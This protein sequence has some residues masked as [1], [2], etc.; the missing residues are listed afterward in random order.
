MPA[1][2]QITPFDLL[3]ELS[4]GLRA[5]AGSIGIDNYQPMEMQVKFHEADT[6]GRV[7]SGGN[8][9]GKTVAGVAEDVLWLTGKH[10]QWSEVFPP[11]VRG[12]IVA[13]D[14]DRG[15]DKIIIPELQKWIPV[16]YLINGK[17]DDSYSHKTKT[18]TLTNGS[19]VELMSYDQDWDK[20]AG[21]SRHFCHFDEEPP[22]NIFNECLARL[23]DTN[24]RWW[25][26][27]TPLEEFSWTAE[28]IYEPARD[29]AL[30]GLITLIE[31]NT[32]QNIHIDS[33][34][35]DEI[36]GFMDKDE[37][38]ARKTGAGYGQAS[39]IF[40]ELAH[41]DKHLLEDVFDDE[42]KWEGMRR[43]WHHFTMMDHGLR[44]PTAILFAAIGPEGDVIVYD[45][46]YASDRLVGDNAEA[47]NARLDE[48]NI[49][50]IYMVGDPSTKNTDPITGTSIRIE[51][52]EHG[53][54]YQLGNN[55]V[56]A[57]IQR[58][59]SVLKHNHLFITKR[60]VNVL[61]E[62]RSY[63]WAKPVSS[64]TAARSNLMEHP[65]KRNDHA[66]DALRYGV[67]TLPEF[68]E[69]INERRVGEIA[70]IVGAV[71][72]APEE[73]VSDPYPVG[74]GYFDEHLGWIEE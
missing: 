1:K 47:Y 51:Y 53:V 71:P 6:R 25:L 11:P 32:D 12:R 42:E 28:A 56:R 57:G 44:N 67:M 3:T 10:P 52:G 20:F 66:M 13:V 26:T 19:F 59:K 40:P 70:A 18:L 54:W 9:S 29:G 8:R 74:A 17:W 73:R 46:Y 43:N 7:F 62:A 33:E 24:G 68:P 63:K 34:V 21:T 35:L 36:V 64:K 23:I 65:V 15:V 38:I 41:G 14:F 39:L 2:K 30:E 50:P 16:E 72:T 4:S 58:V 49:D 48:L 22:R 69:E 55:D 45:E 61:R 31:T 37:Q 27:L 60:C 5:Q